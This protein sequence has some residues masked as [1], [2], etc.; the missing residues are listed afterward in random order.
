MHVPNFSNLCLILP[1]LITAQMTLLFPSI[2]PA[3]F[4]GNAAEIPKVEPIQSV[5]VEVYCNTHRA[6]NIPH[7]SI[8]QVHKLQKSVY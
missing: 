4:H 6:K 2:F 3:R 8:N 1:H 5:S 7:T